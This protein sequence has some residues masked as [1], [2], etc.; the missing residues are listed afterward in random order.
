MNYSLDFEINKFEINKIEFTNKGLNSI[1]TQYFV[2]E[3]WP[4]VYILNNNGVSHAY[5]GETIDTISR[6]STHLQT[7]SKKHF[8]EAVKVTK[9][10]EP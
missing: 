2:N 9:E 10:V 8:E 3:N 6:I 1:Q 4:I 7:L 5:V